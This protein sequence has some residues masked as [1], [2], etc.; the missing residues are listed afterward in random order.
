MPALYDQIGQTY[1]A[2][3]RGEPRLAA[4]LWSAL[5]PARTVLNVGAGTG[6]Y[7]PPDRSVVAVEPS[8]VMLAQRAPAA[9]PAVQARSE[10]LPFADGTFDAVLAVLTAHHW[11][12]VRRGLA[13]CA[14]V[15]QDRVVL[16]TWDPAS[17]GFWL[18][19]DY[20]PDLLTIDRAL[21]PPMATL[22]DALG[23]LVVRPLPIP[24]DCADGFLGAFWR[25]PAAYLDPAVRGGMSSF[26]RVGNVEARVER[27]RDDLASGAWH[28]R[29]GAL[30]AA[31]ALD[32][33]YRL[34]IA[35]R[36]FEAPFVSYSQ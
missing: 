5:G 21:F 16:L 2:R 30:L 20:F 22:A 35:R 8:R 28:E 6:S 31:D 23:E 32:I 1:A 33:G 12:D 29:H 10:S 14:R 17:E 27:L 26:S 7:E 18:V 4:P 3:R 36:P 9:A 19:R 11:A 25:R 15:A 13:E 24:A 34:V